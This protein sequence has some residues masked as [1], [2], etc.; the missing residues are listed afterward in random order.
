[1]MVAVPQGAISA[2][3]ARGTGMARSKG[4][5]ILVS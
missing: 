2:A 3:S 5:V 1:V 4:E